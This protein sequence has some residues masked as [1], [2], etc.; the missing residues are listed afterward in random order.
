MIWLEHDR[1]GLSA[2]FE[3]LPKHHVNGAQWLRH[4]TVYSVLPEEADTVRAVTSLAIFHTAV[5][6]GDV[7][8]EGGSSRLFAVGRYHD[9]LRLEAG[10]WLLAKRVVRLETRVLGIGSHL[11]P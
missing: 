1:K 6:V 3:L 8:L 5:D 7:Q 11:I 10:R 4:A 2:L 9:R